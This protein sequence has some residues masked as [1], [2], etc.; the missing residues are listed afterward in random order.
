MCGRL[1]PR[2]E[3]DHCS[4]RCRGLA[5]GGYVSPTISRAALHPPA[6]ALDAQVILVGPPTTSLPSACVHLGPIRSAL[7]ERQMLRIAVEGYAELGDVV[8]ELR[9]IAGNE[10][11]D[12]FA[13]QRFAPDG[14]VSTTTDSRGG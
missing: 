3:G 8:A 6:S 14:L 2:L 11:V 5:E 4:N 10:G 7:G 13:V 9:S 12:L 1:V